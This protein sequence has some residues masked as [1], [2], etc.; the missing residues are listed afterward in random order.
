MAESL[1]SYHFSSIKFGEITKQYAKERGISKAALAG[2]VGVS[3]DTMDNIYRG[4]VQKIPFELVFKISCA[5]GVP[6]EVIELLWIKDDDITFRDMILHY[7]AN[8]DKT[9][10]IPDEVPSFVPD[11]V[12]DTAAAVAALDTPLAASD[13]LHVQEGMPVSAERLSAVYAAYVADLKEQFGFERANN[14]RYFQLL[15][16]LIMHVCSETD[17][18]RLML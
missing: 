2:R 9:V 11:A 17:P 13:A 10:L 8:H 14:T 15:S 3:Y 1:Q 12:A 4:A 7:D 6:M 5:L 16:E 18:R